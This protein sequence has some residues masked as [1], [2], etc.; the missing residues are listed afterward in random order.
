MEKIDFK[1]KFKQYYSP[2]PGKPELVTPPKM[3]LLMVDGEGDPNSEQFQEAVGA[4]YSVIYTLKFA[5]KKAGLGPDFSIGALEGLWSVRGGKMFEVGKREDWLW[6]LMIWLPD[7][8]SA[9]DVAA[10]VTELKVKKPNPALDKVRVDELDEGQCVQI[11]HVG[12]YATEPASVKIM[13][14]FAAAQGLSQNGRHHEIYLS[15]PRRAAPEK[16]RTIL[17]HPVQ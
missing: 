10:T 8:I 5:R 15:D 4:L 1:Q 3:Q 13:A 17:R 2:K 12:P 16:L 11:M 9:A 6:T 7:E 14:D